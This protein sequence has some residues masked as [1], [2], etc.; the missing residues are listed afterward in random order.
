MSAG[1]AHSN[2]SSA[3]RASV[4]FSPRATAH[5]YS[6]PSVGDEREL[7]NDADHGCN[8]VLPNALGYNYGDGNHEAT[9]PVP[10]ETRVRVDFES[11]LKPSK[12]LASPSSRTCSTDQLRQE[13][14]CDDH[15]AVSIGSDIDRHGVGHVEA[16]FDNDDVSKCQFFTFFACFGRWFHSWTA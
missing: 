14:A 5:V 11:T 13:L 4:S 1:D 8:S 10:S 7:E 15:Q 3:R 16:V 9:A 6:T 2:I 12:P